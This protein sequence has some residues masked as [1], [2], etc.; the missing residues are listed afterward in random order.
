M[1]KRRAERIKRRVTCELLLDGRSYRG[2]V[3]D[4]S[5]TG[6]FVQTEAT[7]APG[8]RLRLRFHTPDRREFEVDVSVA[9]R[10]VVPAQLASVVR[11]GLGLR[12]ERPPEAYFQLIGMEGVTEERAHGPGMATQIVQNQPAASA[13]AP[14]AEAPKPAPAPALPEYRVR[15]K[16]T[17]GPRSRTLKLGATSPD[18][19][20][21][22]ALAE[23]GRG[24]EV[25]SVEAA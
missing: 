12:V 5:A 19:A 21:K 2:I 3:L 8:A 6:V 20:R 23:L 4:L 13:K 17:D 1:G 9:R 24:W 14:A 10:Q 25:L 11:G 22:R 18:D 7:P 15:V 16:Q